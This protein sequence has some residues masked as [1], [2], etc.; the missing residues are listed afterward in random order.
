MGERENTQFLRRALFLGMLQCALLMILLGRM[1]YLQIFEGSYYRHLAEGNRIATRPLLPLRGQIYDRHGIPLAQN[2]TSFQVF[3]LTDKKDEIEETL[4]NLSDLIHLSPEEKEDI[5]KMVKKRRGLDSLI[6]KDHLTWAEVSAIELQTAHLPGISVEVGAMRK[7]PEKFA[8]AHLIGYVAAP[9]E[10]EQEEDP[11]LS[12]PGLKTG[13]V[14]LEKYFDSR[15]RGN[16]GHSAF[17]VNAKRKIVREL[18]QVASI[19]GEDIHLTI[20]A[21]LQ[22]YVQDILSAYES[23]SAV[24]IDIQTGDILA[25]VS[26]PSFD[27]NF[28]PQG[29]SHE[30][31]HALRDNP[32][33][34]LTNKGI[35]GLYPPG[36]TVKLFGAL[37]ALQEGIIDKNTTIFCPGYSSVGD[38]KFH[39][40][41]SHGAVNVSRAITESCDVFFYEIAKRLGIDR[42]A[43]FY[44]AFGLGGG[45]LMGFPH[46]K[47]G[48][49]PTK[50]WKK[51]IKNAHWTVSDTIQTSIGQGYMLATPLEL[52]VAMAR[53]AGGGKNLLPRLEGK[54]TSVFEDLGFDKRHVDTVLE[55]ANRVVNTPSGTAFRRRIPIPG[56]EMGGKTGTSQVRRITLKQ[57]KAGQTKTTHLPWKYREHGLFIGYAPTHAPRYAIAVVIEHAAGSGPAVQAG[58][59]I[60]L[61]AQLLERENIQ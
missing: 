16:P 13:K 18:H 29:I 32:Y 42:L 30:N 60:L 48:L 33:V 9:S 4:L 55:A 36:S 22:A 41:H 35:S 43:T 54:E 25:L 15:L 8:G 47:K 39:C 44:K 52:A 26:T 3:L 10:K 6:I 37:A 56:K 19:P 45:G 50:T 7:Y 23:A 58:R 61:Q 24:V 59:D 27:P 12:L 38:H 11:I 5:Q 1:Y 46:C 34:P 28:F 2:E 14:G 17:E 53:L 49:V 21:C 31:W 57:R 51:E 20:D 40:M